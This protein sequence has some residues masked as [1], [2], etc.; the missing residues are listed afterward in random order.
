MA[1][2]AVVI[3]AGSGVGGAVARRFAR[4]GLALAI[5][6][7]SIAT[8]Q[9]VADTLTRF[10]T[11][12]VSLTADSSDESS[13]GDALD[14]ACAQIGTPEIV[15]YNAAV[16]RRDKPGELP[17]TDLLHTWAVNVGGAMLAASRLLPVMAQY[18]GTFV[19]TGGMPQPDP[20]YTSLSLGK[21]GIRTLVDL[22]DISY[23]PLG[24]HV[25]TVTIAGPV[26]PGTSF[27]PDAIADTYW[28][29]HTQPK[30]NWQREL[31]FG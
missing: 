14:S 11:P 24:V 29:L 31:V 5:I 2:S 8:L 22:L 18:G 17:L 4:E 28:Q 12:V 27:D 21:A 7:R 3:G 1:R 13:L 23:R 16:I 6:S 26:V 9:A 30:E 15:V 10:D 19:V 25:A 20:N